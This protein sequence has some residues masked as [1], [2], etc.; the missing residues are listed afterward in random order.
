MLNL[1][2][3]LPIAAALVAAA[4]PSAGHARPRTAAAP[5]VPSPIA[6]KGY[7]LVKDWDFGRTITTRKQMDGEFYTRYIYN[8]GQLD[9][10][11]DEWE[12]Y[13]DNDNHVLDGHLLKLVA[14]VKDGLKQGGIESGMLRSKWTGKYGYYECCM[15]APR[16]RGMW[17]AF[18]LN[19]QDSNWPPEIDILEIVNNGRDTTGN[20]FHF[21]HDGKG[22]KD[23]AD[24][25]TKLDK[26]GSYRPAFDYADGFHTFAVEWTPDTV[27]HFVDGVLVVKRHFAWVHNDGKDGGDAHVLLNLAV[28][29]SWPGPPQ[30]PDEFPAALE[31]KYIRVWQK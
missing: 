27:T 10:L 13:R 9:T 24:V 18:W 20:S 19:P 6:G 2:R 28:G 30:S 1:S 8:N 29:G 12:R 3:C 4:I 5:A 7:H 21:L 11:N 22:A 14:R 16:G 26:W 23:D 17:P 15:K 31:V 25:E